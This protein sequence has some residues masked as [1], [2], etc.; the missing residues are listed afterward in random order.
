M[1]IKFNCLT[2]NLPGIISL[3]RYIEYLPGI[4]G[5]YLGSYDDPI[6]QV[7]VVRVQREVNR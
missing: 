3:N 2:V 4:M 7:V 5:K 6:S 1:H